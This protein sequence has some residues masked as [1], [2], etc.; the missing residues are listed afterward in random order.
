M[1]I[2]VLSSNPDYYWPIKRLTIDASGAWSLPILPVGGK[3]EVGASYRI[4]IYVM[5]DAASAPW[6]GSD[7]SN[8][9]KTAMPAGSVQLADNPVV[10]G[11]ANGTGP[12]GNCY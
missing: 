4:R 5:S 9:A 8:Q 12:S 6:E 10:R 11:A 7:Q 3:E 1:W 2:V